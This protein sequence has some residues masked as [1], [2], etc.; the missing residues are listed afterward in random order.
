MTALVGLTPLNGRL[1]YSEIKPVTSFQ[2]TQPNPLVTE[3]AIRLKPELLIK[4]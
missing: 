2:N 3:T 1:R 4:I